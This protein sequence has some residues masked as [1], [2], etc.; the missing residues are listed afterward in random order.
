MH[1]VGHGI[2]H[3][4]KASTL[5]WIIISVKKKKYGAKW[6]RNEMKDL[7]MNVEKY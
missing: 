1:S 3:N 5:I 6:P 4:P 2:S 7:Q